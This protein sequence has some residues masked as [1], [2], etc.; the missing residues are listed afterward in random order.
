MREI[1]P[2]GSEVQ[3]LVPTPIV[4][5]A[6]RPDIR[7]KKPQVRQNK[8]LSTVRKLWNRLGEATP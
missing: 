5:A 2:S 7:A 1:R 6:A 3:T 4:V 8:F